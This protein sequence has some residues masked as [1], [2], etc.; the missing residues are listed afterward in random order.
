VSS[1]TPLGHLQPIRER[2]VQVVLAEVVPAERA[3]ELGQRTVEVVVGELEFAF[4]RPRVRVGV[5]DD[6]AY[7]GQG[8]PAGPAWTSKY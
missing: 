1:E 7:P 6:H 4:E 5:A 2:R 8:S 3:A